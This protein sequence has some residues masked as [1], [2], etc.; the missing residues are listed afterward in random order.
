LI[1]RGLL[2]WCF[3][4]GLTLSSSCSD[5]AGGP[6]RDGGGTHADGLPTVVVRAGPGLEVLAESLARDP[7]VWAP[8]PGLPLAADL[9]ASDTV[10]VWFLQ[11]RAGFD[12]LGIGPV[13]PWVAGVAAPADRIIA[14]RVDGTQRDLSLLRAVYRHEL[15][16]VMLH[17]ATNG[18]VPRWVQEGYAQAASGTWN[19]NDGWRLQFLL[20]RRGQSVLVG[21]DQGFRI[22]F[23]PP[24]AYLLSYTAVAALIEMAGEPGLAGLFAELRGGKSF[25]AALRSVYGLTGND[26]EQRWRRQVLDR[27]GWLYL[28]SRTGL[29]WLMVA[30]LVLVMGISRVRRDRLRLQRLV[31]EERVAAAEEASDVDAPGFGV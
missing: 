8:M 25:E 15:A 23:D 29:I 22:G 27:Y 5:P 20:V 26:F 3:L 12:S 24:T 30:G 2:V 6:V 31:E 4:V 18:N 17:A 10:T 14:L 7:F 9:L 16:H 19:W 13:E 1:V 21:L 11:D 28:F